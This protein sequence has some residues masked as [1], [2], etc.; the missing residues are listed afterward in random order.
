MLV[1]DFNEFLKLNWNPP[2]YLLKDLHALLSHMKGNIKEWSER[3][4]NLLALI[5]RKFLF[6]KENHRILIDEAARFALYFNYHD[7]SRILD[8]LDENDLH[9]FMDWINNK[10]YAYTIK[11]ALKEKFHPI[12]EIETTSKLYEE[13]ETSGKLEDILRAIF[14]GYI[15]HSFDRKAIHKYFNDECNKTYHDNFYEHIKFFYPSVAKRDCTLVFAVLD[16]ELKSNFKN[17]INFKDSILTFIKQT[18]EILS[19]HCYLGI[20][21]KP[22][23]EDDRNIQWELYSDIVLFAEKFKEVKLEIGYFHPEK[24]EQQTGSH[25]PAL[26][27]EEAKFD[28]ANEGFFYKD[29][30]IIIQKDNAHRK[31]TPYD[32][33]ILFEK[34]ERDETII[35]CPACRSKK[36]QGN[37]YPVLGVRSWECENPLC[38]D[39]S[40]YNR[41]KR[42]SLASLTKQAA[43]EMPENQIPVESIRKWMLDVVEIEDDNEIIDMLLRHYSL[44][45]DKVL[46][47]NSKFNIKSK[48]GRTLTYKVFAVKDSGKLYNNFYNSAFFKRF[49]IEKPH[50]KSTKHPINN[51]SKINSIEIYNGD[52]FEILQSFEN[53]SIDGAVT[54][55]PYYNARNYSQWPNIYCYL[56]DMYNIAREVYRVLSPGAPF[57]FNIFDYFD[58]ESIIVFSAMGK[59]RMILGAYII[60]L[61]TKIGFIINDNIIWYKGHIEGK[62]NFNQGNTS[63]Y[64]Q[65][66]LNCWEYIFVFS[67]GP[68]KCLNTMYPK[69]AHIKPVIKMIKGK[70]VLGHTAPFP[71]AIPNL[72]LN[73][74]KPHGRIL[75]PFSGAMTT[76]RVAYEKG[77][78]SVNIEL[79]KE[80]C[81]LGLRLIEKDISARQLP[82]FNTEI[83]TRNFLNSLCLIQ[84]TQ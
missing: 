17:I 41:G 67:K 59:K 68:L 63:P 83:Q 10:D 15:F 4:H 77:F 80:Y 3:K 70:N 31:K 20:L 46:L 23:W 38:S 56:Y 61:F 43:L 69:I 52:A 8:F 47:V 34:N 21:L 9:S 53:N 6:N 13:I 11:K 78:S 44:Y 82:L 45:D 35:P 62:R 84:D 64:Y 19:N 1:S 65:A 76:G 18:H 27:L 28:L 75:D 48:H 73:M 42:Y 33:L 60:N 57:L 74:L 24:I 29:C 32:L 66:P 25:I 50:T 72:L 30:F 40:K 2:D 49:C 79:H 16:N 51:I 81:D 54:S 71:K 22:M 55:P 26:D 12:S 5:N 37:S 7:K 36:V 58:N 39:R 14:G